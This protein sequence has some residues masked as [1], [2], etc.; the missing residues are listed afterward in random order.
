MSQIENEQTKLLAAN[1]DRASSGF[2]IAGFVTP[3]VA[4]SFQVPNSPPI[5]IWTVAFSVIWLF[6]GTALHL[7]ARRVLR[8]LKP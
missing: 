4:L 6:V 8:G 5:S 1:L 7:L 2:V 3:V